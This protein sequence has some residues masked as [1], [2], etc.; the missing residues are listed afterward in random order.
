MK[1]MTHL[2]VVEGASVLEPDS[3]PRAKAKPR[4]RV[5]KNAVTNPVQAKPKTKARRA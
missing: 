4:L 5:V 1:D 2:S 3:K